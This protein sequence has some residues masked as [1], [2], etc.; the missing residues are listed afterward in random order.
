MHRMIYDLAIV[1]DRGSVWR[2]IGLTTNENE[3]SSFAVKLSAQ[4][5]NHIQQALDENKIVDIKKRESTYE[6]TPFDLEIL[7]PETQDP[8]KL[9]KDHALIRVRT[10]F[11]PELGKLSGLTIYG[12]TI[13][14]NDLSSRGFFITNENREEKYL[15]ILETGDE[16]LIA[17]LEDYLNYK[18]EIE[19]V[20]HLERKFSKFRTAIKSASTVDE[21]NTITD[22]FLEDFYLRY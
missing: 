2:V 10:I 15:E 5:K 13:L 1:E 22:K 21:V 7:D 8:L 16:Q 9:C 4:A 20:A 18:D 6:F 12:F 14:N 3:P 17:K 11:T 19:A